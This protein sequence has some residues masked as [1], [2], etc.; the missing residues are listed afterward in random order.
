MTITETINAQLKSIVD[1]V[2][3]LPETLK[4]VDVALQKQAQVAVGQAA[5]AYAEL[6]KKG[7]ELV[8]KAKGLT[9]D[10]VTKQAKG[11]ADDAQKLAEGLVADAKA[12]VTKVTGKPESKPAAKTAPVK[13]AAKTAPV[14]PAAKTAP[15]KPA[16]KTAPAKTAPVTPTAKTA[17]AKAAAKTAPAKPAA[18]TAPVT[19]AATTAPVKKTAPKKA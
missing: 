10:D 18:K 6:A 9:V 13:P 5:S 15:V 3:A 8:A 1:D 7:D 2:K 14:K 19:P 12:T 4:N 17:P 16:A 11:F